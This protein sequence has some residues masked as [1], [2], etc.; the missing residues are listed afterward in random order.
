MRLK[1]GIRVPQGGIET[2]ALRPRPS[3]C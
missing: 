2:K 3:I 1:Q